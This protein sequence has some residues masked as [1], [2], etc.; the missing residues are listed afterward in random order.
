MPADFHAALKKL[1]LTPREVW[2]HMPAGMPMS[3]AYAWL[4]DNEEH[5]RKPP[6]YLQPLVLEHLKKGKEA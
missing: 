4:S 3:T 1:K 5:R 2:F 6:K